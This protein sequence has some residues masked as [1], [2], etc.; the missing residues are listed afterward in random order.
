MTETDRRPDDAEDATGERAFAPTLL[1]TVAWYLLPVVLYAAW[2]FSFGGD[3]CG[4]E[5]CG[6]FGQLVRGLSG[7]LPW[8]FPS[9]ALSLLIA[10]LLRLPAVGWRAGATGTAA[11]IL[12]A[13]LTTAILRSVGYDIG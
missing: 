3:R 11:A 6:R 12:G 8:A 13:G 7:A 9:L 5:V 4:A 10:V 1:A 2:V